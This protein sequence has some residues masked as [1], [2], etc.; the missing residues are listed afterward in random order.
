MSPTLDALFRYLDASVSPYHAVE[1]VRGRLVAAGF[2]ELQERDVWRL[3]TGDRV[4]MTRGGGSLAAFAIGTRSPQ[5][6]GFRLVGAHTDSPNLRIK[7]QPDVNRHGYRQLAVET[8]GGVLLSTWM[9]RDLGIA[10]RVMLAST[11]GQLEPR[12]V[13]LARPLARIPN[14]AIHLNRGVNTDGLILNVQRHMVPVIGLQEAGGPGLTDLLAEALS[15][16]GEACKPEDIAGWDLGLYDLQGAT[17]GGAGGEFIHSARLDNLASCHAALQALTGA[18]GEREAT[19]GIVLYDHEEVGSNSAQG[20][21]SSFLRDSLQRVAA[22][23]G[24]D[25]ADA[26]PRAIAQSL[27]ISADMAHAVHP[28]Y[29][30][31]HEPGHK[32]VLGGG[33][34]LK[35]HSGQAYATDGESGA[36]F[37]MLCRSAGVPMQRFVSRSDLGCGSTIGP[38]TAS[39]LGLRTVDV[40]NPLLSMHSIREM[41]A[42]ADVEM[43]AKVLAVHFA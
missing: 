42:T 28:N 21:D 5:D 6:A 27:L 16:D 1:A 14:L 23:V 13:N 4:F 25:G 19:L 37:T 36:R 22:A 3:Q 8:Y 17:V 15:A 40:G 10:G 34:V 32:P 39:K 20:A 43:M 12:L 18:T 41:A 11:S 29:S 38:I 26:L 35:S 24:G 31:R 33:P 2:R 7:P 9:D 30:D